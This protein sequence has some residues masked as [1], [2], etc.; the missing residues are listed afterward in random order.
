M[1]V[2]YLDDEQHLLDLVREYLQQS[3]VDIE[4]FSSSSDFLARIDDQP[5]SIVIVDYRLP[6]TNGLEICRK[7]DGIPKILVTGELDIE[8]DDESITVLPKPFRLS[9]LRQLLTE[10]VH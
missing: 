5:A 3:E 10:L 9:V 6:D 1:R 7:I 4:V 8:V 2:Y